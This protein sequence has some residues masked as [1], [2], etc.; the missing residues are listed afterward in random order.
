MGFNFWIVSYHSPQQ[1]HT[2]TEQKLTISPPL[3]SFQYIHRPPPPHTPTFRTSQ[4]ITNTFSIQDKK[5]TLQK[6]HKRYWI[7]FKSYYTFL[8]KQENKNHPNGANVLLVCI[9]Y[10]IAQ[11]LA[12]NTFY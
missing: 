8:P 5:Q 10:I 9:L 7:Q 1:Q 2:C 11:T 4:A 6:I 3:V 12:Q